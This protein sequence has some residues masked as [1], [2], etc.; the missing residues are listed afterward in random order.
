MTCC[1]VEVVWPLRGCCCYPCFLKWT[2]ALTNNMCVFINTRPVLLSFTALFPPRHLFST[3]QIYNRRRLLR[4]T[5]TLTDWCPP[6]SCSGNIFMRDEFVFPLTTVTHSLPMSCTRINSRTRRQ[7]IVCGVG[8]K[9]TTCL[10]FFLWI[11]PG[12]NNKIQHTNL[13]VH[14][15]PVMDGNGPIS[16]RQRGRCK[17]YQYPRHTN[18]NNSIFW[19]I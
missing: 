6:L 7:L 3:K 1:A 13:N 11:F 8:E 5:Q 14:P 15:P 10:H 4:A 9:G 18:D 17:M 19:W 16:R 12:R 2:E